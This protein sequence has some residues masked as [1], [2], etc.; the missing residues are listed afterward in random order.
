[1]SL[2]PPKND[3]KIFHHYKILSI[4]IGWRQFKHIDRDSLKNR[5]RLFE[6]KKLSIHRKVYQQSYEN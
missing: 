2:L 6:D 3:T 5:E 4:F 1:M